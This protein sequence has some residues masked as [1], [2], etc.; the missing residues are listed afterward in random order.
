MPVSQADNWSLDAIESVVSVCES[1]NQFNYVYFIM[2]RSSYI[3]SALWSAASSARIPDWQQI[4]PPT[5]SPR[6]RHQSDKRWTYFS[7]F[8][9]FSSQSQSIY[10]FFFHILNKPPMYTLLG[11]DISNCQPQTTTKTKTCYLLKL[12][13]LLDGQILSSAEQTQFS[14][15]AHEQLEGNSN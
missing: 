15:R 12:S 2:L 7:I 9:L 8:Q 10:L 14:L 13:A 11:S 5:F 4:S 1:F 6:S 3:G